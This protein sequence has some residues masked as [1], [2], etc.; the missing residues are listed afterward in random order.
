MESQLQHEHP[1]DFVETKDSLD[2]YVCRLCS[3]VGWQARECA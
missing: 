1:L 2:Q 3:F